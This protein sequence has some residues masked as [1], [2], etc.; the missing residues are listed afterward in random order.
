[1]PS[2]FSGVGRAKTADLY[3]QLTAEIAASGEITVQE[4]MA[5]FYRDTDQRELE[6]MLG[7]LEYMGSIEINQDASGTKVIF[8]GDCKLPSYFNP[9]KEET[10]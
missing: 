5:R 2:V 9:S 7:V 4:L 1:M 10:K 3:P 8:K 6:V